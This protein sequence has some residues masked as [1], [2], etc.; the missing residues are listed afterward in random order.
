MGDYIR[1]SSG[2]EGYVNDISWRSTTVR[3]L[4]NNL[5]IIPNAKLAQAVVT[6][7]CLPERRVSLS[8]AVA[9]SYT[10]DP[11]HV[12]QVL[13]EEAQ[14]AVGEVAGLLGEPAPAAQ[15]IPGFGESALNFTLGCQV[16]EFVDQFK[17]QHELRKRIVKRFRAEGIAMPYPTRTVYVREQAGA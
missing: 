14:K 4:G 13:V 3:T 1:L 17:V 12:E 15:L 5:I 6:N 10:S 9:V 2:E 11:G 8:I 7:Y 16:A